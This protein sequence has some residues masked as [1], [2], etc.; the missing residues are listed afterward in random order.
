MYSIF[1][2]DKIGSDIYIIGVKTEQETC[3]FECWIS[4]KNRIYR[5]LNRSAN[6]NLIKF[7]NCKDLVKLM[8]RAIQNHINTQ[9]K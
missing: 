5:I 6:Q 3:Y 2:L 9:S 1:D 8:E 7:F 4:S